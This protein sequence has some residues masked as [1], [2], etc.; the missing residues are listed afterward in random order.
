MLII[1]SYTISKFAHFLDTQ[2]RETHTEKH[3]YRYTD[4]DRDRQTG[5]VHLCGCGAEVNTLV[6][7]NAVVLHRARLLL[8]RVT[9][10]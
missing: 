3:G 5:Q 7:I 4:T 10:C 8:G 9:V 1:L 6:P 2:C